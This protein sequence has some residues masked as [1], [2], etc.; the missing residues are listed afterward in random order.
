MRDDS[1]PLYI[2]TKENFE[3]HYMDA[4]NALIEYI[5]N[6]IFVSEK[7]R[8][9]FA[10]ACCTF[11]LENRQV[12]QQWLQENGEIVN[13]K[14][15]FEIFCKECAKKESN[16]TSTDFVEDQYF[17][18]QYEGLKEDEGLKEPEF[19]NGKRNPQPLKDLSDVLLEKSLHNSLSTLEPFLSYFNTLSEDVQDEFKLFFI[20][21]YNFILV[22]AEKSLTDMPRPARKNSKLLDKIKQAY[23]KSETLFQKKVRFLWECYPFWKFM[24][25]V[26][27]FKWILK[28]EKA[29][30]KEYIN[31]YRKLKFD[32]QKKNS[33][34]E[35]NKLKRIVVQFFEQFST[36]EDTNQYKED[37][38]QSILDC[39]LQSQLQPLPE[40]ALT[41]REKVLGRM[42]GLFKGCSAYNSI[43]FSLVAR[44]KG[45]MNLGNYTLQE[46][47]AYFHHKSQCQKCQQ[48]E[49]TLNEVMEYRYGQ[50]QGIE[51]RHIYAIHSPNNEPKKIKNAKQIAHYYEERYN[52]IPCEL[53][54]YY[55]DLAYKRNGEPEKAKNLWE[56]DK[57]IHSPRILTMG[58][59][60]SVYC[61]CGKDDE[62]HLNALRSPKIAIGRLDEED[63]LDI[64]QINVCQPD[65]FAMSR[66]MLVFEYKSE[67][68]DWLVQPKEAQ[69]QKG[70]LWFLSQERLFSVLRKGELADVDWMKYAEPLVEKVYL[71]ELAGI[72]IFRTGTKMTIQGNPLSG[73]CHPLLG[74]LP[75]G[76]YVEIKAQRR[77]RTIMKS[78]AENSF[79]E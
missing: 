15:K 28:D 44:E 58:A 53:H 61:A 46:I 22:N 56:T 50:L 43:R 25:D 2:P 5:Y 19:N 79:V 65:G 16:Y 51:S 29:Q 69:A 27:G 11:L 38:T 31:L 23:G 52:K 75:F 77:N 17:R 39:P 35:K 57:S 30:Q 62:Y 9:D 66:D 8:N 6:H 49:K 42:P 63:P 55:L 73:I 60:I 54:K 45:K 14:R 78:F 71:S 18:F 3:H 4:L 67:Q 7:D 24:R 72:G 76:W 41:I 64:P 37:W 32:S 33:S 12:L 48:A 47:E 13:H 74:T 26:F 10:G 68:Q 20:S 21:L 36:T 59:V 34:R 70:N 1:M 40:E